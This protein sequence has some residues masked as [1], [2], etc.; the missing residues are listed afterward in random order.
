[1]SNS[2]LELFLA[3]IAGVGAFYLGEALYY[4]LASRVKDRQHQAFLDEWEE[5]HWDD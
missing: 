4:E 2:F 5:E 1:M 3:T